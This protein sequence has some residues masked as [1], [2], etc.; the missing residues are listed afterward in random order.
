VAGSRRER[1]EPGPIPGIVEDRSEP[2][3][4]SARRERPVGAVAVDDAPRGQALPIVLLVLVVAAAAI[5]GWLLWERLNPSSVRESVL[6]DTREAVGALYAYDYRDSEGSVQGKLDVL[7]GDLR[8]QYAKDLESGGI[9]DTYEQVSATTRY[10]INDIG[11]KR[12][13]QAQ[14][15]A[16]LL[17]FGRYVIESVTS[18]EQ[19]APEGSACDVTPQGA[20]ACTQI[21][22]LDVVDDDGEWKIEDYAVL[23]SG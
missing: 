19:E 22:R 12:I 2:R 3:R 15:S 5:G 14:D 11:L 16:T 20:Q 8:D 10:E 17:V 6:A 7:T 4:A 13:N 23:A 1:D 18:G 9:I 21:L